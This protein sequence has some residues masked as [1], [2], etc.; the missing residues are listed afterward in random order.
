MKRQPTCQEKIFTNNMIDKGLVSK[1][2]K[3]LMMLNSIKTN[4][5]VK[6]WAEPIQILHSCSHFW[7]MGCCHRE[8]SFID[9]GTR[10]K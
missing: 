4:N 1:T 10:G 5:T 2:Y 3:E 6:K 7:E 9:M 8:I